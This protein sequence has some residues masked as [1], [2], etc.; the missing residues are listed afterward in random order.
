MEF[1][2]QRSS[3]GN[4]PLELLICSEEFK[5][6]LYRALLI[7]G[8]KNVRK[9]YRHLWSE[10]HPYFGYCY[11]VTELLYHLS[12]K[13]VTPKVIP[14]TAGK[15]WYVELPNGDPLDLAQDQ[16]YDYS[17]GVKRFFMTQVMS[18]RTKQLKEIMGL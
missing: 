18:A 14:T 1:G 11:V 2:R 16:E 3:E 9:Q 4:T 5:T 8:K 6:E 15:H 17:T 13:R 7:L 12:D 10:E